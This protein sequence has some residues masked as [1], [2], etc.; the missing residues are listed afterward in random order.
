MNANESKKENGMEKA[1]EL[2][3]RTLLETRSRI[4]A[5]EA[6]AAGLTIHE[7]VDAGFRYDGAN[8]YRLES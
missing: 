5:V 1:K 4:S 3:R 7:L 6:D 2:F 8:G